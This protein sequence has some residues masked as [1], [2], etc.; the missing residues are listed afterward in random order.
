MKM[1]Q[2]PLSAAALRCW[3]GLAEEAGLPTDGWKSKP[4]ARREDARVARVLLLMTHRDGREVVLK[5]EARPERPNGFMT[6]M[7]AHL[8][9][10]DGFAEGMPA[11]LSFDVRS[12][13]CAMEYVPGQPLSRVLE[14]APDPAA[15][16]PYLRRTG[17]WLA[18]F[19]RVD[20][21]EPRIFQPK[22]S[23]RYL[24]VILDEVRSGH[25]PVVEQARFERC[26]EYLC[27]LQP[28]YEGRRTVTA[29]THGD[30]HMRNV[31][32]GED[33][34]WGIDFAGGRV[35]PVGH[36]VARLL[37]DYAT[38]RAPHERVAAGMVLPDEALRA[39]FEGY[40]LVGPDDPS[41]QL[42][43]RHRVLAD[44]W[45]LPAQRSAAQERRRKRLMALTR[46][47]FAEVAA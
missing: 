37:V 1:L 6:A 16:L 38:L 23:V 15:H 41:V 46:R 29:Q 22:F 40:D 44:W 7:A 39:F 13:A 45:G 2:D 34:V 3:P 4:L 12:Q 19:H 27:D 47:V 10:Q 9:A 25:R 17:A 33:R 21:G 20:L 26:A 28:A 31:L 42:L 18:G 30:L 14:D 35:V 11:L 43:L 32:V 36:D 8:A 5:H 24:R